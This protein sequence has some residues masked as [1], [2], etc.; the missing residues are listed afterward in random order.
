[1]QTH[2]QQ[3]TKFPC[4]SVYPRVCSYSCSLS[5]SNPLRDAIYLILCYPLILLSSVFSSISV[6][7]NEL[8]LCIRWPKYWSFSFSISP[9]NEYSGLI[10]IRIYWFDLLAFQG[11]HKS[12]LQHHS[13]KA[14][15]LWCS[16]FFMAQLSYHYPNFT[17]LAW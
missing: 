3:Y 5:L 8:A 15:I 10:T 6:F 9:S 12:F 14:S 13:L 2:G 17:S 7:S 4:L 11:T 16:A 1:M